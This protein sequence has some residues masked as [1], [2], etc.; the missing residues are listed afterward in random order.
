MK[1]ISIKE[2]LPQIS[3]WGY[4]NSVLA[5]PVGGI[6]LD[7]IMLPCFACFDGKDWYTWEAREPLCGVRYWCEITLPKEDK[8]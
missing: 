4:S 3:E 7:I 8:L 6:N 2:R 5:L 1:W